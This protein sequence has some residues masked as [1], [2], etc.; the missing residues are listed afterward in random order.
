MIDLPRIF[1]WW[2]MISMAGYLLFALVT[3]CMEMAQRFRGLSCDCDVHRAFD[4]VAPDVV[5]RGQGRG[6]LPAWWC[7]TRL[8]WNGPWRYA[9][10][11][12]D[13]LSFR[14]IGG[15]ALDGACI[16]PDDIAAWVRFV[17]VPGDHVFTPDG[18][19]VASVYQ[20]DRKEWVMVFVGDS[21]VDVE[22]AA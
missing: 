2:A 10:A 9:A 20:L 14:F 3:K 22:A 1:V 12:A 15:G 4:V 11:H 8:R 19:D 6:W 13:A 21:A 17:L 7:R 16:T 18:A 5:R